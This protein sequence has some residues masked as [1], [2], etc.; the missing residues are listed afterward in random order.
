MYGAL[1]SFDR[2]VAILRV[3]LIVPPGFQVMSYAA[4]SVFEIAN[5]V[6]GERL[7]GVHVLSEDGG[8][9]LNSF[10][11]ETETRRLGDEPFDTILVGAANDVAP[12]TPRIKEFLREAVDDRRVTTHWAHAGELQKRFPKVIV[13]MDRIFIADGPIWTSAGMTA[14]I[15]LALGLVE[16]D[17]GG[18]IARATARSLVVHHRRAGGQ[19]QHSALLE[20]DAKS[21]RVQDALA[22]ARKNLREALTVEQLAEAARLST[23]QF[24]RVFRTE[25]GQSPAKAIENLR[26]EA[27]RLLLEQGRLPVEA[28]ARTIGFGDRERMRRSFLRAFGQTPQAIRNASHP[29]ASI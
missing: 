9:V 12:A 29:L 23:R 6:S 25:T 20:L 5:A 8:R 16:R 3:G 19:S 28:I 1:T 10:G 26:L 27:A 13:E 17:V 4:L 21:D 14:G 24:S 18:E 7:Y 15:D 22:F 11:M 2:E